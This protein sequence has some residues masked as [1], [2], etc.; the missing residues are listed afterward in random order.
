MTMD[1]RADEIRA[2][3]NNGVLE[4]VMPN[5]AVPETRRV[6]VEVD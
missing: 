3:R 6:N 1:V 5:Q 2:R 4:V